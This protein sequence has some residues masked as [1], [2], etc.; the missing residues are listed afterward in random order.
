M[1]TSGCNRKSKFGL[2]TCR[3]F[4]P[5]SNEKEFGALASHQRPGE[6]FKIWALLK[7]WT[8]VQGR[9]TGRDK[10]CP[11]TGR[12]ARPRIFCGTGTRIQ[13]LSRDKCGTGT[14]VT[15]L[16]RDKSGTGTD[17]NFC[18]SREIFFFF[19]TEIVVTFGCTF[20]K[21][22]TKTNLITKRRRSEIIYMS[23]LKSS[24]L[25][26]KY[27]PIGCLQLLFVS[28]CLLANLSTAQP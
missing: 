12:A 14:R 10:R 7:K 11:G 26:I 2:N 18:Q 4:F 22:P 25:I 24:K 17:R 9:E 5:A 27:A 15:K 23:A 28:S 21:R 6:L 1:V 20:D 19:E 3:T 13:K 8:L 16:S